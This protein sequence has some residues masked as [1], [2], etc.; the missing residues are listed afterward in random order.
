MK[1]PKPWATCGDCKAAFA[2]CTEFLEHPCLGTLPASWHDSR[3]SHRPTNAQWSDAD[4]VIVDINPDPSC[5]SDVRIRYVGS[6]AAKLKPGYER[7]HLRNLQEVNR[8][9]RANGV[10]NHVMH[11]DRNGTALD[12]Y[13]RDEKMTH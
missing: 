4:S 12:D 3:N 5:P 7:V 13:Y 2:G 10:A 11:Y 1:Q 6:H 9:E 8:F